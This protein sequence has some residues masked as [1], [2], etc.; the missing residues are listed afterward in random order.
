MGAI[1]WR[2]FAKFYIHL[3]FPEIAIQ[4]HIN[5]PQNSQIRGQGKTDT[6]VTMD[7]LHMLLLLL[8]INVV[9]IRPKISELQLQKAEELIQQLTT[10]HVPMP[11]PQSH[12]EPTPT[13][14]YYR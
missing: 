8:C 14:P 6:P 11:R 12:P 13:G 7:K 3:V 2:C 1:H 5:H 4:S 9:L 10:I